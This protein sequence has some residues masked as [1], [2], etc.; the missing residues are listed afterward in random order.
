[1]FWQNKKGENNMSFVSKYDLRHLKN[2][3]NKKIT[4]PISWYSIIATWFFIG[5]IPIMPGT[6]GSLAAYPL[7]YFF[8]Q[9][10]ADVQEVI[11]FLGTAVIF[12]TIIGTLAVSKFQ[13]VT[14]SHDHS[15][16]VIDEVIG[17]LISL[18]ICFKYAANAVYKMPFIT[19][20]N[21]STYDA[22]FAASFV[23]FRFFDIVKPFFI[24]TIDR[25]MRNAFSVILDDIL[26]G[27]YSG[28]V[29]YIASLLIILY[30]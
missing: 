19:E 30:L 5:R 25:Q 13:T 6:L 18:S 7:Y 29:V 10:A 4:V 24:K 9:N 27:I 20:L 8:V 17:Q 21:I 15:S 26:A 11:A 14:M 12:L 3:K 28:F 2:A 1:L 23:T 16:V 22:I